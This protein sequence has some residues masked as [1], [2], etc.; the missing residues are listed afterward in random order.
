MEFLWIL[1]DCERKTKG[2]KERKN[3]ERKKEQQKK[4]S[5]RLKERKKEVVSIGTKPTFKAKK[6]PMEYIPSILHWN[7]I[8]FK[9]RNSTNGDY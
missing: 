5:R 6:V 4:E 8:D 1:N 7:F 3:Q 2:R 9:S